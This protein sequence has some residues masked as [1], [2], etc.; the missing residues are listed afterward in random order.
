[1]L[2][3]G[4]VVAVRGN[5]TTDGDFRVAAICFSQIPSVSVLPAPADR[6]TFLALLSGLKVGCDGCAHGRQA[7]LKFLL[8]QSESEEDRTLSASVERV[9]LCGGLFAGTDSS[10]WRPLKGALEE[11]DQWLA[12]LGSAVDVDVVPGESDPTNLSMPQA[13]LLPHLFPR[14]RACAKLNFMS[15]PY[16]NQIEGVQVLGHSGQ[17]VRDLLRCTQIG[18]PL[19]ALL[20]TL[21]ALHMAPTA[22]ETLAMPPFQER[23]PFIMNAIPHIFFSAGHAKV[24]HEWRACSKTL[25]GTQCVCV[26]S[27]EESPTLVLINLTNPKDIRIKEFGEAC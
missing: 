17:P 3:S 4:L 26:P 9:V 19:N 22:P 10:S 7:L 14:A 8:N 6:P 5:A 25:G 1:M 27:F 15:N 11:A 12:Q 21:E 16:E 18:T 13:P 23:D 20:L 2:C 24:Q